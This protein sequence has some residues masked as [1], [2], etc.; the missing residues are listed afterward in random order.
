MAALLLAWTAPALA[1]PGAPP[2]VAA[3]VANQHLPESSVSFAIIDTQTGGLV[4][5]LNMEVP[6]SPASTI[7]LVTTFAALDLLGPAYV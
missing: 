3:V 1:L 6:R 2:P 5:G 7:K 4:A